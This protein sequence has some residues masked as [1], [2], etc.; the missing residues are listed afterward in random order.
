[1]PTDSMLPGLDR[2][3]EI[4]QRHSLRLELPPPLKSAPQQGEVFL[5]A[6]LDPQLAAVY[7][8][9]GAAEFGEF[10][11]YAPSSEEEG[12]TRRNEWLRETGEVQYLSALVFGWEPGFSF[13]YGTVPQL[14]DAQGIQPVIYIEAMDVLFAVPIAS[15]VDRLFDLYSR[16]LELMVQDPNYLSSGLPHV[17]F[18]WHMRTFVARDAP[19]I[20]QVRAGHFDFLSNNYRGALKW[21][22]ELRSGPP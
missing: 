7:H 9:L 16:Y 15:S 18:P 22:Q 3:I 10:A 19:L 20:Q 14:A 13:Y 21:L 4:C 6:P 8:R 2:L 1:M 5:G 11:L 17:Q 12:L